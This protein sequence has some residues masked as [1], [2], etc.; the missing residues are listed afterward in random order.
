MRRSP[1][2]KP[3]AA[4]AAPPSKGKGGKLLQR[5]LTILVLAP[6][7]FWLISCN[8]VYCCLVVVLAMCTSSVE[9]SGLKRHLKVAILD[10]DILTDPHSLGESESELRLPQQGKQAEA[11]LL[12]EEIKRQKR[13]LLDV[14]WE[15]EEEGGAEGGE[16]AAAKEVKKEYDLPIP[17]LT[18]YNGVKHLSWAL[19]AVCAA[20]GRNAFLILFLSYFLVF[21]GVTII[22]HH[23][24]EFKVQEAFYM[25]R[26][27]RP[28]VMQLTSSGLFRPA[29]D[30]PAASTNE[31][32]NTHLR[33]DAA[34]ES[35]TRSSKSNSRCSSSNKGGRSRARQEEG[36]FVELELLVNAKYK[37]A[38]QFIDFCLDLF[39]FLWIGG[40]ATPLL[41]YDE[42]PLG[43]A[44]I[45]ATLFG[46]FM[47]DIA[48]L[49]VGRSVRS[50]AD[51]FRLAQ[52]T[53]KHDEKTNVK[54]TSGKG[55][56][57]S[58]SQRWSAYVEAAPHPLYP[59]ISPNK[60]LEGAVAGV[61]TNSLSFCAVLALWRPRQ[62][63]ASVAL[64]QCIPV[65]LL[66]G[67][68]MGVTGVVGDLLQSLLKRIAKV[69]DAGNLLPGHGGMLDR[70]DG[71][72]LT[73]PLM[74]C[75][76]HWVEALG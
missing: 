24:L 35:T 63:D 5:G 69:K 48:A 38:E 31:A 75:F 36:H 4:G 44:W 23:R 73:F 67:L 72:L 11:H 37:A 51:S 70:V 57:L 59:S 21:V 1:S 43:F 56:R 66:V 71:L 62:T 17:T 42:A 8:K 7:V 54:K 6:S 12:D 53:K 27:M 10:K 20:L 68:I 28:K 2:P 55:D 34:G 19:L 60:S 47:N 22:L 74:Y 65:W 61:L 52:H 41:M 3:P 18:L 9:W 49:L 29:A 30:S 26:E 46:N 32:E 16:L 33:P 76:F 45:A 39:G 15:P 58:L 13:L 14:E 50:Y 25:V 64:L 40:I